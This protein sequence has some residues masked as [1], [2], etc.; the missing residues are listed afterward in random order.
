MSVLVAG[1]PISRCSWTDSDGGDVVAMDGDRADTF[2]ERGGHQAIYDFRPLPITPS[3]KFSAFSLAA[4]LQA[5][6]RVRITCA[7]LRKLTARNDNSARLSSEC[8]NLLS[9]MT[10]GLIARLRSGRTERTP[11]RNLRATL[12]HFCDMANDSNEPTPANACCAG[13]SPQ[14]TTAQ[15]AAVRFIRRASL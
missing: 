9:Q 4:H 14:A 15:R 6:H 2:H 11:G 10:S 1:T 5:D 8:G 13:M 3:R 7:S 12:R